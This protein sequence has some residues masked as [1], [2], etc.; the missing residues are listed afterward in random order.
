MQR[1][2]KVLKCNKNFVQKSWY[3]RKIMFVSLAL[4]SFILWLSI[5]MNKFA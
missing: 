1:R 5:S 4:D 3:E 2:L